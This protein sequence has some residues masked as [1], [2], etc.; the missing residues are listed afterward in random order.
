MIFGGTRVACDSLFLGPRYGM[1][2]PALFIRNIGPSMVTSTAAFVGISVG[3]CFRF[4]SSLNALSLTIIGIPSVLTPFIL[5]SPKIHR[6]SSGLRLVSRQSLCNLAPR[7]PCLALRIFLFIGVS[8]YIFLSRFETSVNSRIALYVNSSSRVPRDMFIPTPATLWA[9]ESGD[10]LGLH[11]R[12]PWLP[13]R[14]P[15]T[16]VPALWSSYVSNGYFT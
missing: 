16:G 15:E 11:S 9:M 2:C 6:H 10:D 13:F 3:T 8:R 1:T 7:V 4:W 12:H 5:R 14:L